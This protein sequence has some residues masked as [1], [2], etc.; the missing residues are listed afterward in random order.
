MVQRKQR[1]MKIPVESVIKEVSDALQQALGVNLVSCCVYGS[2]VRGNVVEGVSDINLLL[3]LAVSDAATH[4]K[5]ARVLADYPEVD[6]FIIPKHGLHRTARCFATKFA[7]IKRNHR[8]LLGSDPFIGIENDPSIERLICEQA[9][10]NVRLRLSHAYSMQNAR[11]PYDRFLQASISGIF[12]QLSDVLRLNGEVIPKDFADRILLFQKTFGSKA[13]VLKTLHS[14]R[15][16]PQQLDTPKSFE[17]HAQTLAILDA[18]LDIIE[19][20]WIT[21]DGT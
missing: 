4:Q 12:I 5:I 2:T 13:E 14:L 11:R 21:K 19:T 6:P 9:L 3:V 17:L 15:E 7:S 16:Q 10:R 1:E 18:A 8:L 20:Q